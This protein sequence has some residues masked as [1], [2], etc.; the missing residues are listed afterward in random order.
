MCQE[1]CPLKRGVENGS[2]VFAGKFLSGI[3][4]RVTYQWFSNVSPDKSIPSSFHMLASLLAAVFGR[5]LGRVN[6]IAPRIGN[7]GVK[8]RSTRSGVMEYYFVKCTGYKICKGSQLSDTWSLRGQSPTN[9]IKRISFKNPLKCN[10]N[11]LKFNIR[12][13]SKI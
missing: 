2:C 10:K 6:K 8:V 4:E 3:L 11:S 7:I 1:T 9:S 5:V 12:K 13:I